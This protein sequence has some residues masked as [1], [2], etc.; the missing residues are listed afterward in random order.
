MVMHRRGLSGVEICGRS[1][2]A[3]EARAGMAGEA[4]RSAARPINCLE[5]LPQMNPKALSA[6]VLS[7]SLLAF[8]CFLVTSL[9]LLSGGLTTALAANKVTFSWRASPPEE[10]ILG[11]RLYYGAR[12]R[13]DH[14]HL[15]RPGFR[16]D[17]FIDFTKSQRCEGANPQHCTPLSPG[18]VVCENLKGD[19]PRCTLSGVTGPLF[20]AMTAYNAKSESGYSREH[21]LQRNPVAQALQ[22]AYSLLLLKHH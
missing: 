3:A 11:Y 4:V 2:S 20:F 1:W 12:S 16:Y 15:P 22:K 8:C 13:F 10:K 6:G 7:D 5:E 21:C 19:S 9:F 17:W 14:A 18:E